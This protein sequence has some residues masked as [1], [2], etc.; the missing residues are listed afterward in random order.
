MTLGRLRG[1]ALG[2]ALT[3]SAGAATG[4]LAVGDQLFELRSQTRACYLG[5]IRLYDVEYFRA[6]AAHDAPGR[7]VRVSYLRGFSAEALAEATNEVFRERHGDVVAQRFA[8]ELSQVAQAYQPVD[9]GDR[10]TYCVVPES[11]G[12]LMRDG[13]SVVRVQS[14]EFAERFLQIWVRAEDEAARPLW[15]F[16]QC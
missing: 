1:I 11:A 5:F 14:D 6:I 12:V 13:R 4:S 3:A 10:Y 7:C 2:L 8:R 16:G 9:D 15:A